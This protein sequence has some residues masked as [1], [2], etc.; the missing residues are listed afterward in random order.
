MQTIGVSLQEVGILT[1]RRQ[2]GANIS[3]KSGLCV[4]FMTE[5]KMNLQGEG[6][7]QICFHQAPRRKK[8]LAG[9]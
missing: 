5:V 1:D 9:S 7:L 8:V 6:E 2:T 3:N 4:I